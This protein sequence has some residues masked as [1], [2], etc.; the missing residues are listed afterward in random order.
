[1]V[2][3]ENDAELLDS[4]M[5]YKIASPPTGDFS[6][7]KPGKVAWDWWNTWNL[8][9]VDFA[10]GINT[11]TYKYYIDFASEHGIEY[12]ILD[13]GW[14]VNK[15]ADLMQVVPEIDLP[16][17]V[18]YAAERHVGII[19]WAGYWAFDRDMENVC[20]HYSEMG[21]KGFK[22]DFMDRDDQVMVAFNSRAAEMGAKYGLLMDLHGTYKPT[23]L[24]RTYPNVVNFEGV[25]G[26]EQMKW[27]RISIR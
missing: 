12:V 21:I 23:G 7:V 26:L 19:L 11:E 2:V 13:E 15:R 17:I 14:A 16:G 8:Y 3:A 27:S 10:A 20:R 25:N 22:V 9:G 24:Q 1:M 18:A 6:W 4:D 5:V